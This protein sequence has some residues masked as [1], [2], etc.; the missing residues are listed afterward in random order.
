MPGRERIQANRLLQKRDPDVEVVQGIVSHTQ[1]RQY[2]R[3]TG[4]E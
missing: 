2:V 3:V 4:I 1:F